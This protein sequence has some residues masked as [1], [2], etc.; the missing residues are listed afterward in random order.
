MPGYDGTGPE[1]RGPYGRGLGPCSRGLRRS[2]R[3]FIGFRRRGG[4]ERGFWSFQRS[5]SYPAGDEKSQLD[6]ERES[7]LKQLDEI[8]KRI[9]DLESNE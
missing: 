8:N 4:L 3:G 1:G 7:L 5:D 6:Y 2:N 9:K